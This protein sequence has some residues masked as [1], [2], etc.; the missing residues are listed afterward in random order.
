MTELR[1]V[2]SEARRGL[3][4]AVQ[5][6]RVEVGAVRP[7]HGAQLV[8]HAHLREESRVGERLEYR[9]AQLA[10]ERVPSQPQAP[11]GAGFATDRRSKPTSSNSSAAASSTA[12]R[13]RSLRPPGR[14]AAR[15]ARPGEVSVRI[16]LKAT[17]RGRSQGQS[18]LDRHLSWR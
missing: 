3:E 12:R 14:V 8:V 13:T 7:R 1:S 6:E 9:P 18:E 4:V 10:F 17:R 5:H 2:M 16:A 11:R 15:T